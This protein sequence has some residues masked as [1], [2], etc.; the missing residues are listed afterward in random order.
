MARVRLTRPF[1]IG[2]T[3]VTVGEWRR[4]MGSMSHED[5]DESMPATHVSWDDAVAFCRQ[6]S[7]LPEE[8]EQ[9]RLYRIP[10]SA[11]WEYACRAGT[12]TRHW[13]GEED[14]G[15]L[16]FGWLRS[17]SEGKNHPVGL[18]P[19]NP[20]GLYD[21]RGNVWE[22][23]S[24]WKDASWKPQPVDED[25]VV[26]DPLGPDRS[27]VQRR[28]VRGGSIHDNADSFATETLPGTGDRNIGFRIVAVI[29][30]LDSGSGTS[31]GRVGQG[32]ATSAK[33]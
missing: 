33:E 12:S 9:G 4:V 24:D 27:P 19:P 32:E 10:T 8:K 23:V 18:K 29:D 15:V 30:P 13:F 7:S 26:I 22:W 2:Q 5:D 14:S 25:G 16:E 28:V 11:E 3:E 20:W 31:A 1:L 6:L 17:N 21:I